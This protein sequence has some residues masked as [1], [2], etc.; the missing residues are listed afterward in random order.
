MPGDENDPIVNIKLMFL[1]VLL[2]KVFVNLEL[3]PEKTQKNFERSQATLLPE[4]KKE[5]YKPN[6][7]GKFRAQNTPD[8]TA[9]KQS[10]DM[11]EKF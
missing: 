9:S 1:L 2:K 5:K 6:F 11:I 4:V 3:Y 10:D 7:A 8:V